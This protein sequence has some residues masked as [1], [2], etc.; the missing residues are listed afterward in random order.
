MTGRH[1][2]VKEHSRQ[3][4]TC[5]RGKEG[6][7]KD[8]AIENTELLRA[9]VPLYIVDGPF[10]VENDEVSVAAGGQVEESLLSVVRGA[11]LIHI[12]GG[13]Y[14]HRCACVYRERERVCVC[15]CVCEISNLSCSK[16]I[17]HHLLCRS[18]DWLSLTPPPLIWGTGTSSQTREPPAIIN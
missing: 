17:E 12:C 7:G 15:V 11:S 16:R 13:H 5:V 10:L 3:T 9:G 8:T 6:G 2:W 4:D 14:Q 18:F 1:H